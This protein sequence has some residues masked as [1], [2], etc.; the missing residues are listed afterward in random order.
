M[1]RLSNL[2]DSTVEYHLRE[3]FDELSEQIDV[4]D[5]NM[6]NY[7]AELLNGVNLSKEWMVAQGG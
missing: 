6:V 1:S 3:M 2:F 4:D 7:V 5:E